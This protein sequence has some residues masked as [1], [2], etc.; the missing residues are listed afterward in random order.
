[1]TEQILSVREIT[2][3]D[4]A[5]ITQYWLNASADYLE[6]MGVDLNK[7]PTEAAWTSMLGEQISKPYEQKKSYCTI[8]ELN[9][10]PIGHC[11]V[12]NISFGKEANMH[13]HIWYAAERKLRLGPSF[14]QLSLPYFFNNLQLKKI[15]CEPYALNPSPNK[16]I[17][18]AGF[19][20]VKEHISIPGSLNH[21][22]LVSLWEISRE[23]ANIPH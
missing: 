15:K 20:F 18:K 16:A 12:N 14:I 1:M 19:R 13:L 4:V 22:Q 11:N 2:Q 3:S 21:E 9:G 7:M 23:E 6:G 17:A 8:W 5:L 10:K